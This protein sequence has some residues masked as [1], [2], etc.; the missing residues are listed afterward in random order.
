M[1]AVIHNCPSLAKDM[2][3]LFDAYW[4]MA[5]ADSIPKPWPKEYSTNIN[6]NNPMKLNLN[7]TNYNVYISVRFKITL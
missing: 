3:K 2:G 7:K 4:Y 1:G 6:S 5:A